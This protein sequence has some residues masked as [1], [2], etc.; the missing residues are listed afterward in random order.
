MNHRVNLLLIEDSPEFGRLVAS[1]LPEHNIELVATLRGARAQRLSTIDGCIT[2][3]NLPDGNGWEIAKWLRRCRPKLPI[4]VLT[5]DESVEH[6]ASASHLGVDLGFKRDWLTHCHAFVEEVRQTVAYLVRRFSD[7]NGLTPR[8]T[9]V[10]H[11]YVSDLGRDEI[12][13]R[14]S[15]S[16][17][18]VHAHI[19][20]ILRKSGETR[21]EW[22]AKRLRRGI[23][24]G[25]SPN[26]ECRPRF[27]RR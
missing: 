2:D 23:L 15:I 7:L 10:L 22:L 3:L 4:L 25:G 27:C 18:T 6:L 12:A 17:E 14:L 16:E 8:Q 1:A 19:H 21:I 9:E 24:T 11:L 20:A 26:G 5:G 13:D